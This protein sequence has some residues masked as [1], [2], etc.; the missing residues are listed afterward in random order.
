MGIAVEGASKRF[1]DFQALNDV[2]MTSPTAR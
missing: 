2:S 1:G